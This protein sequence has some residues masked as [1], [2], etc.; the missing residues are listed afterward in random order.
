MFI[1]FDRIWDKIAHRGH[2]EDTRVTPVDR[3]IISSKPQPQLRSG[4]PDPEEI[5]RSIGH[6]TEGD[7]DPMIM[8]T[9]AHYKE[10]LDCSKIFC[11]YWNNTD[12]VKRRLAA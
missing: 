10:C 3:S 8:S 7:R 4:H 12:P 1:N 11:G 6:Y 9:V 2:T 5:K